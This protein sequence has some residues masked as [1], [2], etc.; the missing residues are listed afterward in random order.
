MTN[1]KVML[2]LEFGRFERPSLYPQCLFL[3][4]GLGK[5]VVEVNPSSPQHK[6]QGLLRVDPEQGFR[7]CPEGPSLAAPNGSKKNWV[8]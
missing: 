7:R 6:W 3:P 2:P 8:R 1:K 4:Y 5:D